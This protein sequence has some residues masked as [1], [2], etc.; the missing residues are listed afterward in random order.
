MFDIDYQTSKQKKYSCCRC[1]PFPFLTFKSGEGLKTILDSGNKGD[2]VQRTLPP[3]RFP[4]SH[5]PRPLVCESHILV[6]GS[7]E[8]GS[9]SNTALRVNFRRGKR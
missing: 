6:R 1:H 5:I 2:H 9:T 7:H 8:R 4:Q 3:P